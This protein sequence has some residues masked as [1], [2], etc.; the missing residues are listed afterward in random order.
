MI[1]PNRFQPLRRIKGTPYL[2]H[3]VISIE[4]IEKE[5]IDVNDIKSYFDCDISFRNEKEGVY[6]FCEEIEEAK[7]LGE[8]FYKD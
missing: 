7:I 6:Y 3:A 8:K 2:I 1:Y 5:E 4:K